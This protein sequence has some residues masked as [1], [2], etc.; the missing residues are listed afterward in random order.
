MQQPAF[1]AKDMPALSTGYNGINRQFTL[2]GLEGSLHLQITSPLNGEPFSLGLRVVDASQVRIDHEAG[3]A[4][5]RA[6]KVRGTWRG[7]DGCLD[8]TVEDEMRLYYRRNLT[9]DP[10]TVKMIVSAELEVQIPRAELDAAEDLRS[11]MADNYTD[12][13]D[14]LHRDGTFRVERVVKCRKCGETLTWLGRP[15]VGK[16]DEDGCMGDHDPDDQP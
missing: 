3:E 13:M 14:M 7:G 12:E 1:S 6:W 5:T 15:Q 4:M 16:D 2:T 8:K 9:P 11:W 10:V